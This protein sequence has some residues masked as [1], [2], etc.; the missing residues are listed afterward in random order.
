[1]ANVVQILIQAKDAAS[2]E[3][4]KVKKSMQGMGKETDGAQKSTKSFADTWSDTL[5]G[6][7][8]GIQIIQQVGRALEA[9]FDYTRS[10]AQV[11][12]TK[13]AFQSLMSTIGQGTD[14][15]DEWRDAVGGTVSDMELMT[16]FQTLAAGLSKEMTDAFAENNVKLLEISKAASALNP[17]LGTTAQMYESI[18]RGI[19]R[20]SPLILDNL[21][22]VVKVGEAN[23]KMAAQLGK[24][25]DA[26]T[27]EEKQMAL[28]NETLES[29]DRLI[30][31]LGGSVEAATDP[32]DRYTTAVKNAKDANAAAT[33]EMGFFRRVLGGAADHL[34][35]VAQ[36][37]EL[38]NRAV[39]TGTISDKEYKSIK[40]ALNSGYISEAEVIERLIKLLPELNTET[41][42]AGDMNYYAARAIEEA[43]IQARNSRGI[44]AEYTDEL[45]AQS[46]RYEA[47][48][49]LTNKFS[50][51]LEIIG[52]NSERI[53]ELWQIA[54]KGGYIDGVYMSASDARDAIAEL[55][56]ETLGLK[57]DMAS[58]A[59]QIVIDMA[60][61]A[62]SVDGIITPEEYE[63]IQELKVQMG[64][65]TREGAD[66][67]IKEFDRAWNHW[68]NLQFGDKSVNV[69][70]NFRSGSGYFYYGEYAD[71]DYKSPIPP[72]KNE[73]NGNKNSDPPPDMKALGGS[74]YANRAHGGLT[75]A[76]GG[77][78]VGEVGPEPFIPAQDGRILSN[79]QAV[80]AMREGAGGGRGGNLNINIYSAVNLA[81]RAFVEQEMAPIIRDVLRGER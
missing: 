11:V 40:Q 1:M 14:V 23:E 3:F 76:A 41:E 50:D 39:D 71:P 43:G 22:I 55:R 54:E 32:W 5:L 42:E 63:E 56:G 46:E 51:N 52:D 49:K 6:I 48:L 68:Q 4:D 75:H 13:A 27:A 77:Y 70:V 36:A 33:A 67:A 81:D 12:Q 18:T 16:G 9:A 66:L 74:V 34:N 19:K 30:E 24:S 47:A 72:P 31:Q 7:N 45:E 57:D 53:N 15:L 78:W 25:V 38:L 79:S 73:G 29:G 61:A 62:A 8:Q 20:Q 60:M 37:Q 44:F 28:L 65:A 80:A 58:A 35:E 2:K 59:N 26:L 10:G 17:Q 64:E 69:D 21:G